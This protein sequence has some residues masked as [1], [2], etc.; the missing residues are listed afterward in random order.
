M[1][2]KVKKLMSNYLKPKQN[3]KEYLEA[4]KGLCGILWVAL[5][6]GG[7][8]FGEMK[9]TYCAASCQNQ[10]LLRNGKMAFES[11]DLTKSSAIKSMG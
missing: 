7:V 9:Q 4:I 8:G 6:L 3:W 10:S 1:Y 2:A 5:S 11:E